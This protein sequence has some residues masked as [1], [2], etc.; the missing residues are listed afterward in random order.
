LAAA[1]TSQPVKPEQVALGHTRWGGAF[2]LLAPLVQKAWLKAASCLTLAAGYA[3][4]AEQ[5]VLTA[6]FAVICGVRLAF[7]F[8]NDKG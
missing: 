4:T 1:E 6:I 2:V 8:R 7:H 5:L 3:V